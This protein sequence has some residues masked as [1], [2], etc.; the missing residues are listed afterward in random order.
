M[1][2]AILKQKRLLDSVNRL[3][4]SAER[5]GNT[6]DAFYAISKNLEHQSKKI[7]CHLSAR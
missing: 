7:K 2:F 6:K 5:G 1:L 4:V 3:F